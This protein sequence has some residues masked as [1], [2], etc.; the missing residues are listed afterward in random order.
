MSLYFPLFWCCAVLQKSQLLKYFL[1]GLKFVKFSAFVQNPRIEWANLWNLGRCPSNLTLFD[2]NPS[3]FIPSIPLYPNPDNRIVKWFAKLIEMFKSNYFRSRSTFHLHLLDT[4][5]GFLFCALVKQ[6]FIFSL[7]SSMTATFDKTENTFI[8]VLISWLFVTNRN[9]N[10]WLQKPFK[11]LVNN[12][13]AIICWK[14]SAWCSQSVPRALADC[15]L[16]LGNPLSCFAC[17]HLS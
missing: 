15:A 16:S 7:S 12:S 2:P 6:G 3:T 1:T 17:L 13:W 5:C 9:S 4:F 10:S 8:S 11:K 14:I